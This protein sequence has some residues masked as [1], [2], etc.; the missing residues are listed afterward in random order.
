MKRVN[1]RRVFSARP[2]AQ[3]RK[4]DGLFKQLEAREKRTQATRD[5]INKFLN[6]ER[7]KFLPVGTD[8]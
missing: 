2:P 5:A 3:Q 6:T 4:L 7:L 8:D 1:G